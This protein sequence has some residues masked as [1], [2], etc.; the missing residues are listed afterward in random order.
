[1]RI[2]G[3]LTVFRENPARM[4]R[5]KDDTSLWQS[6]QQVLPNAHRVHRVNFRREERRE[7]NILIVAAFS[8]Q[9]PLISQKEP[10]RFKPTLKG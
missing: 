6:G 8:Q 1:V 7:M 3:K 10:G 5:P 4:W 2:P 9:W